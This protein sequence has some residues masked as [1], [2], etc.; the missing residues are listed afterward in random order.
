MTN[1]PLDPSVALRRDAT[2]FA[3]FYNLIC[4]ARGYSL[5][6]HLMPPLMALADLR[7][8]NLMLIVGP[9]SGKSLLLSQ[10]YPAWTLGHDPTQT[11]IAISAGEL[12]VQGFMK[13]VMDTVEFSEVYHALFPRV[14]PDKQAGWSSER[15]MFVTGREMGNP[16]SNYATAGLGSKALTGKHARIIICDD[17]H[18]AENSSTSEQ[19]EKV[20]DLWYSTIIGRADPRGCR[21]IVAG[22]RWGMEDIYAHL[23]ESGD[24][25]VLELPA[26]REGTHHLYYDITYPDDLECCFSEMLHKQEYEKVDKK[27]RKVVASP[28]R[29]L[30]LEHAKT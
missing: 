27:Y 20:R 4:A 25:V 18:D 9:G 29:K 17:I 30:L 10:M 22:R 15:G 6:P 1:L 8:Q 16:D 11:L 12:L 24:F 13:G 5:P 26:E 23:M 28:A 14:R 7:I 2:G 21:F 3:T 19:C